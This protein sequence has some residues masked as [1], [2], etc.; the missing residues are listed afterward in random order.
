MAESLAHAQIG[1]NSVS[2]GAFL[3]FLDRYSDADTA[4][5]EAVSDRKNLRSEI[6]AAGIPLHAFDRARKDLE[7]SGTVRENEEGWYRRMMA[8]AR[9]PVGFQASLD[10]PSSDPDLAAF[11]TH[12]LH[13]IDTQGLEAGKN[14]RR[15]DSNSYTP[16]TEAYQ[17]WDT[18]W[19]RGQASIAERMAPQSTAA[20]GAA[21]P[22]GAASPDGGTG[23]AAGEDA[24]PKRRG[25]P[26][27]SRN[28]PKEDTAQQ[29][30][31]PQEEDTS[32]AA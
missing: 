4:V 18:A 31:G 3:A 22:N 23:P 2:Q 8:W 27:G 16:G 28:R 29:D 10:M 9:K 25:R 5:E 17:R 21:A 6:K 20:N 32:E 15:R 19:V 26:R 13:G 30:A 14:G 24:A 7:K 11:N 1:D 12:E